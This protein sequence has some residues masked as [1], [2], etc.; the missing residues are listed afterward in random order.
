KN[1][2]NVFTSSS[3]TFTENPSGAQTSESTK[4]SCELTVPWSGT[5]A[6]AATGA[7]TA[8][9]T[10]IALRPAV[11]RTQALFHMRSLD[12]SRH[13]LHYAPPPLGLAARSLYPGRRRVSTRARDVG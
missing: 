5:A 13:P 3:M 12:I 11:R 6:D 10:T 8:D 7:D 4:T 2:V 1:T 9:A